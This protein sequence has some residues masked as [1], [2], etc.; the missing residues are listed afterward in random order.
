[1]TR[2]ARLDAAAAQVLA[3]SL[4]GWAL[5]DD[6]KSIS[7]R[8]KFP[9]FDATMSYVNRLAAVANRHDHHP[10]MKVGYNYC[11]VLFTTHDAGGLTELDA[12]C[13]RAAQQLA[14]TA[15][16]PQAARK[17]AWSEVP[18]EQVN[19]SMQRRLVHGDRIMVADIQLRDGFIVPQ[20][21]HVHEQVT[22][23]KSGVLRFCLGADRG[24]VIDVQ[25][26]EVLVIPANLPH[27]ALVIGGVEAVDVFTPLREDW[28]SGT[29]DY[30]RR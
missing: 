20:H 24:Q 13:A 8:F 15:A 1:M 9:D 30:L 28:I 27:E 12:T 2:P 26:G 23:V 17:Y 14:N 10:D 21:H 18:A 3:T 16:S 22:L 25:A 29:D 6:G 7:R 19:P 11:E 4:P 5:T